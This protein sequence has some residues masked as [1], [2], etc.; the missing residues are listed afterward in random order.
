MRVRPPIIA[1][2]L[3]LVAAMAVHATSATAQVAVE[4]IPRGQTQADLP[5]V[6]DPNGSHQDPI[7]D[8]DR[9]HNGGHWNVVR[10]IVACALTKTGGPTSAG[11]SKADEV[12]VSWIGT[13]TF[14][15]LTLR[16]ILLSSLSRAVPTSLDLPGVGHDPKRGRLF[17]VFLSLREESRL[18]ETFA[19]S[20]V[21]DTELSQLPAVAARVFPVL[22]GLAGQTKSL[23]K[24]LDKE[25]ARPRLWATT[26][27]VLLPW[28]RASITVK[29]V[30]R[31]LASLDSFSA[32]VDSFVVE[33]QE[34]WSTCA[35]TFARLGG[36]RLK[37]VAGAL[38]SAACKAK[39]FGTPCLADLHAGLNEVFQTVRAGGGCG[40]SREATA[41]ISTDKAFRS[42]LPEW[43][44][45]KVTST[46]TFANAPLQ[47]YS[48][49]VMEG[50]AFLAKVNRTRVALDDGVLVS[51]PLPRTLTIV[52]V[53][54]SFRGYD[55]K[56]VT[57]TREEQWRWFAG[58]AIEPD[59]GVAAGLSYQ[60]V[61]GLAFNVGGVL[62]LT[63]TL[64]GS[65]VVGAPPSSSTRTYK[66]GTA[67]ALVVGVS[68]NFK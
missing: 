50:V 25:A 21:A 31:E 59:F 64:S 32:D 5:L 10:E 60:P 39:A 4:P 61:R 40:A 18:V 58:A 15:N 16:R 57:M 6:C 3:A 54:R 62:L 36:A 24:A 7:A 11:T 8:L 1:I 26:Y 63:K 41:M 51:D 43:Y 44:T 48:F 9:A 47:H 67:Q 37:D 38:P 12:F 22:A 33:Q 29:S 19:S 27:E 34:Q 30:A 65:D 68:Y 53:N 49:G 42:S 2:T 35:A 46:V 56:A 55:A 14:G 13:D 23:L 52:T 28:R 17:E 20:E 66:I 45:R